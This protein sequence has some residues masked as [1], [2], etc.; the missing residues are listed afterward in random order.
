[1]LGLVVFDLK[2]YCSP[3][4]PLRFYST[5]GRAPVVD[6]R[7][8]LLQGQAPDRG[9]YLPQQFPKLAVSELVGKPYPQIAFE[10][11]RRFTA[12]ILDE[13][14]LRALCADAYN[15]EVPLEHVDDRVFVLRLDRGPTASFK[16]FAARL[17]ARLIGHFLAES[18]QTLTI[19]T[20]TSGDTGSAVASAFHGVAGVRVL[21]LFPI[22]EVS[23]RQRKQMT[24]L[25]G[26]V[27]TIAVDG[28]FDDCQAL[29]KRAF[30]DPSL[31][32]LA[33]SSA[34]SINIG[35]LLPQVVY[36]F[37]AAAQLGEPLVISVPS[38]NFGNMMGAVIAREMG[39]RIRKLVVPVNG[40]DE[41]P[42]FLATG[43]YE[44]IE[45]SRNCLSNAMNVGHPSNL[46]RLVALYGGQMDEKGILHRL[47]DM[48]RMRRDL[49]SVSVSDEQ[50]RAT[51][52]EAWQKHRL[53]LEPHGAVGWRGFLEYGAIEPLGENPAV[54]LE[55]AH[56]AKFPEE[57]ERLLGFSPEVPPSL[58]ALDKLPEDFDRMPVDYEQ[59]R[60]YLISRHA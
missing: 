33:L 14:T 6:L 35:R 10:V 21:V 3:V 51:I 58:A 41:F 19:L 8:A 45:P 20:A 57:I 31:A 38:G 26:N 5:N 37:Y 47:P 48:D 4:Q 16:D 12:G 42:R 39:L 23:D 40:N 29:V 53:L 11:L 7:Q 30:A 55:T 50:T 44:K 32:S 9:L 36:Y 54:V 34:N 13:A 52:R 2:L 17:M 18:R 27:R 59:F 15:F 1:V 25:R 43:R 28:K 46:A 22:A 24:T 56:P 49:F 60:K